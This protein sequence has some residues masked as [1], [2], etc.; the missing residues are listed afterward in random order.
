MGEHLI[1]ANADVCDGPPKVCIL[2]VPPLSCQGMA[3]RRRLALAGALLAGIGAC[4]YVLWHLL[5][6]PGPCPSIRCGDFDSGAVD[7][8]GQGRFTLAQT[9]VILVGTA[10]LAFVISRVLLGW[11]RWTSI[12]V[13]GLAL[14]FTF[15]RF[16]PS[17]IIGP[18][19]SVPC[20]TPS[21][22][23]PVW[24]RCETGPAPVD[25][26]W[27]ERAIVIL[28]GAAFL[29]LGVWLDGARSRTSVRGVER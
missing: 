4:L 18:A 24:G 16:K 3:V 23:G 17:P 25:H 26:R 2:W 15:A 7:V 21:D 6:Y 28:A 9:V 1:R 11:R 10:M 8:L 14:A 22:R 12:G 20:S 29:A 27:D 5:P 19:P 13:V